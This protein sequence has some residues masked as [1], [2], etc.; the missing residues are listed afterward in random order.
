MED[1]KQAVKLLMKSQW[2]KTAVEYGKKLQ[3]T[4]GLGQVGRCGAALA[5]ENR[6]DWF[7]RERGGL[8][9]RAKSKVPLFLQSFVY[10]IVIRCEPGELLI[11]F[12]VMPDKANT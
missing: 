8:N 10:L 9:K 7:N 6:T 1:I 4:W 3:L 2:T 11:I 12:A 5:R